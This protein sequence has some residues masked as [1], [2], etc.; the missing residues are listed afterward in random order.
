[1]LTSAGQPQ[2]NQS[3]FSVA[4]TICEALWFLQAAIDHAPAPL[5]PLSLRQ[6]VANLGTSYASAMTLTSRVIPGEPGTAAEYRPFGYQASCTCLA[7]TGPPQPL[8]RG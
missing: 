1:V 3:T 2:T 6:G 4:V 8:Q 5:S 7:Y